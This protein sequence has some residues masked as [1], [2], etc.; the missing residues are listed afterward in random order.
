M[1]FNEIF[2]N[3]T[4]IVCKTEINKSKNPYICDACTETLPLRKETV[5]AQAPFSYKSP[6]TELILRF[7]YN[8][9]GDVAKMVAPFMADCNIDTQVLIPV[10][11]SPERLK[12]RGYNQ[13]LLLAKEVSV[14]SK[15]PVKEALVRVKKTTAQKHMRLEERQRNLAGAFRVKSPKAV[16]GKRVLLIDDVYTTGTTA[17][18]CT[19]A[20]LRAKAANVQVL[21]IARVE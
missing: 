19:R 20:L 21:T 10:P 11:L 9:E 1:S 15:I 13:A 7:K 6:I 3:H 18:E 14:I 8:A 4:C 16:R 2:P 17:T 12:Q 5:G